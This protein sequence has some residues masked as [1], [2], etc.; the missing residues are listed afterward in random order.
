MCPGDTKVPRSFQGD[1]NVPK[2]FFVSVAVLFFSITAGS[3]S[4]QTVPS[5]KQDVL[6]FEIG[7]GL[8]VFNP[9]LG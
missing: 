3:L 1:A 9:D 8:S 2:G 4:A 6:P 5:A 7:G